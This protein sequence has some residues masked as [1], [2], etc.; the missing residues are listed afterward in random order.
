LLGA[1]LLIA[2][3]GLYMMWPQGPASAPPPVTVEKPS[4]VDPETRQRIDAWISQNHLNDFGDPSGTHYAGGTPLFNEATG[5]RR[6]RYE[7]ILSKHPE[8]KSAPAKSV[9]DGSK[10]S[11]PDGSKKS[12]PDKSDKSGKGKSVPDKSVP[13]GK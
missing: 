9:P 6:D 1:L 4:P 2:G 10:K 7:Y 5:E 13:G 8:L 11:V 3:A 12:V